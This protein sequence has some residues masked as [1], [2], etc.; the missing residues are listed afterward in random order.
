MRWGWRVVYVT[1]VV[2]LR[3]LVNLRQGL[4]DYNHTI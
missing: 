2:L 1:R 4:P 3:I